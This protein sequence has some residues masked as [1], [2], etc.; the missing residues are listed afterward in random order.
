MKK[1]DRLPP[2][3]RKEEI[4]AAAM[5][6]FRQKGFGATTMEN[7]VDSVSLSK[8]GVYRLYPSTTAILQDLILRG[9]HLRNEYYSSQVGRHI[10]SGEKMDL[11]MLVEIVTDSLLLYPEYAE[12]YVEFLW[13]KQ[14][15]TALQLLYQQICKASVEETVELIRQVGAQ[16][17]LLLRTDRLQ[18]MTDLMNSAIL[19]MYTLGLQEQFG[20][21]R[22]KI[23]EAILCLLNS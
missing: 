13:E 23:T 8:G 1:F 9:M 17:L 20:Q 7:I 3:Q 22:E 2:A 18:Q 14:R 5:K 21:R 12:I 19:S 11:R 15:N 6:L 10:E 16:E 4:Q